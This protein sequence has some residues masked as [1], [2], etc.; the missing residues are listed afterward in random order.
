MLKGGDKVREGGGRGGWGMVGIGQ[1]GFKVSGKGRGEGNRGE[2]EFCVGLG[3]RGSD[4]YLKVGRVGD[5][6]DTVRKEVREGGGRWL[7][8]NKVGRGKVERGG[9]YE[10]CVEAKRS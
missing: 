2:E 6:A 9:G 4:G 8:K 5:K 7:G 3:D 10:G 1:E